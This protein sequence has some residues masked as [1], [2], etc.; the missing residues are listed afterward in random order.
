MTEVSEV[1]SKEMKYNQKH[2]KWKKTDISRNLFYTDDK[3]IIVFSLRKK[4][5]E[6]V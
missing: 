5:P 1:R 3:A 6:V 2:V 4:K